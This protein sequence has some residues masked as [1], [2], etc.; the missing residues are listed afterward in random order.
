MA[1][2]VCIIE[3]DKIVDGGSLMKGNT[4]LI[5]WN[6]N[7]S[8]LVTSDEMFGG[9]TSLVSFTGNLNNLETAGFTPF[10]DTTEN[11]ENGETVVTTI[12][13][14]ESGMFYNCKSLTSFDIPL[15]SLKYGNLMFYGTGLTEFHVDLSKLENGAGMFQNSNL[16]SFSSNLSSL[17]TGG[18]YGYYDEVEYGGADENG[19]WYVASYRYTQDYPVGMFENTKISTWNIDLPNLEDGYRMFADCRNLISFSGDLNSLVVAGSS[20]DG[21]DYGYTTV[22]G[23]FLNCINLN[24][25]SSNI[26][27]V[28]GADG[29]FLNCFSLSSIGENT[30]ENLR[31]GNLMFSG[32]K[33]SSIDFN[34]S[35]LITANGM[36]LSCPFI[37]QCYVPSFYN[38]EYCS[39]CCMFG[40]NLYQVEELCQHN[41]IEHDDLPIFNS[42]TGQCIGLDNLNKMPH[43]STCMFAVIPEIEYIS[44]YFA[45]V[46]LPLPSADSSGISGNMD[47]DIDFFNPTLHLFCRDINSI[48]NNSDFYDITYFVHGRHLTT[49][50]DVGLDNTVEILTALASKTI[51]PYSDFSTLGCVTATSEIIDAF[52]SLGW[53]CASNEYTKDYSLSE[54]YPEVINLRILTQSNYGEYYT[55]IT[56]FHD[57]SWINE[58]A[59]N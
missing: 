18:S 48:I 52:I 26:S 11:Y 3:S 50:D 49:T 36:F 29:M 45:T 28:E 38:D 14:A 44:S 13:T 40:F 5:K 12:S 9:C 51:A 6:S 2:K 20:V 57:G 32:T 35:S 4:N 46:P 39:A 33:I 47:Y 54:K 15:P 59:N 53:E 17:I 34:F 8:N 10:T 56:I 1:N 19:N 7:L 30:L 31:S 21:V 43:W 27:S 23:M 58:N 25:F 42:Y 41:N 37:T 24:S 55:Y 16:T 22:D